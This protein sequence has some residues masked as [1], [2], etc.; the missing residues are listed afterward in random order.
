M[1]SQTLDDFWD[2]YKALPKNV[3]EAACR[4]YA[5]WEQNH[6]YPS[7]HFKCVKDNVPALYSVRVGLHYRALGLRET[8]DEEDTITWFWIGTHPEYDKLIESL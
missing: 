3:R 1:I 7:L 6:F 5:M 2:C 4:A 8:R